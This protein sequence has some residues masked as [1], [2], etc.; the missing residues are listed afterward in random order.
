MISGEIARKW[1]WDSV[2]EH[3]LIPSAGLPI[4]D[5]VCVASDDCTQEFQHATLVSPAVGGVVAVVGAIRDKWKALGGDRVMGEPYQAQTCGLVGGGCS[6][7]FWRG[8]AYWSA[9]SGAHFV[10]PVI[11]PAWLALKGVTGTLGYPTSDPFCGLVRAGCGQQFQNGSIYWSSA[12]GAHAV[13]GAIRAEYAALHWENNLGYPTTEQFCGLVGGG[14]G[15]HFQNGS[16]YWSPKS[17]AHQI[18][19][20]IYKAWAAS[21]WEHGRYG[22]PTGEPTPVAGGRFTQAFQHGRLTA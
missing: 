15:Q 9:A 8:T 2:T 4:A 12:T 10:S 6:Q 21:G 19:G 13:R 17:G 20:A 1:W 5:V 11:S 16:I 22:Y 18:R 14:C 3:V 7:A